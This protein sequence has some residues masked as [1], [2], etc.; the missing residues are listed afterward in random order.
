MRV[1][2][3]ARGIPPPDATTYG[4]CL[5]LSL[6]R[7]AAILAGVGARAAQGNASSRTAEQVGTLCRAYRQRSH[8][9][10][11]RPCLQGQWGMVSELGGQISHS[12]CDVGSACC[13]VACMEQFTCCFGT[14]Q[15][16]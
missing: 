4:F 12:T 14:C 3:E 11:A 2:S 6:F 15:G 7:M 10:S 5:A 13:C 1:Y 16:C 8:P 9:C